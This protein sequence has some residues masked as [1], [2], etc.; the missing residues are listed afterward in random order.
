MKKIGLALGGGGA[1]GLSHIMFIQA[2]DELGIKPSIIS[3][4][5]IGSI[6]GGFYAGGMTGKELE[7]LTEHISI[8]E[9]GKMLDLNVLKSSGIVRGNGVT[10]FL[11]EH[12]PVST[13][14]ELSIPLKIIATD[15][16]ERKEV[17]FDSGNLI[18]AIRSSISIPGIFIPHQID[19]AILVDGG[20]I[21]P[22]PMS[23]IRNQCDVLIAIDVS[24]TMVPPRRHL[25]PSVFDAVMNTF[26]I[27]E[28]IVVKG[29]LKKNKPELYVKPRL[30][31]IQIL[32]FHKAKSIMKSVHKDVDNFKRELESIMEEKPYRKSRSFFS[33]FNRK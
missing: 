2:L 32:D 21:N 17:V 3:G 11:K 10:G 15:F 27:M 29:H 9:I 18:E 28:S 16:W 6:I 7:D 20:I 4:T 26:Q 5:S 23:V 12:L 33:I 14:E 1:R 8:L 24:G 30:E 22:L 19:N 25:R 13:F 31:N